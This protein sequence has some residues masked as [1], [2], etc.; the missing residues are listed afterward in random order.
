[1]VTSAQC[2]DREAIGW[3]CSLSGHEDQALAS[4]D[5]KKLGLI[6]EAPT[7]Q[8]VVLHDVR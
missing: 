5:G 6:L 2:V 4:P 1:M 3:C 8:A 7:S